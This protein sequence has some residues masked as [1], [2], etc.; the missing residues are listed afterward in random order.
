MQRLPGTGTIVLKTGPAIEPVRATVRGSPGW[1]TGSLGS[2][3][4]LLKIEKGR[5]INNLVNK[6]IYLITS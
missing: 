5:N 1:T 3:A 4:G 6:S 2:I